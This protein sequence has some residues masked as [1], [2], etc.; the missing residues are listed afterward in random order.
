[1][2]RHKQLIWVAIKSAGELMGEGGFINLRHPRF[3][4]RCGARRLM[5]PAVA[6]SSKCAASGPL[7]SGICRFF[8]LLTHKTSANIPAPSPQNHGLH[9]PRR[10]RCRSVLPQERRLDSESFSFLLEIDISWGLI[11]GGGTAGAFLH[12]QRHKELQSSGAGEGE[13]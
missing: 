9:P 2:L 7:C 13:Q 11:S 5:V 3:V 4:L 12:A 6:R 1:M 10:R 8:H